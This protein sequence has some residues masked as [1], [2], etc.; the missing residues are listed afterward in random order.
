MT[1]TVTQPD[2]AD[3]A[4]AALCGESRTTVARWLNAGL[5]FRNNTALKPRDKVCIGD[6]LTLDPPAPQ[7]SEILAQ[8]IALDI[9]YQDRHLAVIN[10][11]AGMVVH[12]AAGNR[13]GTL[14]NAL[15]HCMEDLSGIGG[16]V[17]PGIV[18]R[19]DKQT[20]G[21]L[22]IAKHDAAHRHLA[23]Q[24]QNRT[25]SRQYLALARGSFSRMEG[26]CEGPIGR[27]PSHRQRMAVMPDGRSATTHFQVLENFTHAALLA[28]KLHTGRTHQIRVHLA[29]MGHPLLDDPLYGIG[30]GERQMLHAWHLSF[31][32]PD[33]GQTMA[34]SARPPEDFI[35]RVA[36]LGQS[37][38]T[39]RLSLDN[40]AVPIL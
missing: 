17:R 40:P 5:V 8:A 35:R 11:P 37:P 36:G 31:V 6:V 27:H 18:H 30:K 2:R 15:L 38:W 12:P 29:H 32:H 3:V 7:P 39:E 10:K 23:A 25:C 28:C 19:L 13:E 9:V 16:E 22:V 33:S 34:F 21:L 1:V 24:L 4:L 20:S 26:L 14:V